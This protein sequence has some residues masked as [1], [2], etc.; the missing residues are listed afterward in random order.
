MHVVRKQG[1]IVVYTCVGIGVY[2]KPGEGVLKYVCMSVAVEDVSR[3]VYVS[4]LRFLHEEIS[5]IQL[6][7][8]K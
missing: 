1:S 3:L 8:N 6:L 5:C 7:K 4:N 2:G